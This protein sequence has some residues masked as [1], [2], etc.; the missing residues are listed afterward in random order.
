MEGWILPGSHVPPA[1]TS[2]SLRCWIEPGASGVKEGEEGQ[3]AAVVVV[4]RFPDGG[5]GSAREC[6]KLLA[7]VCAEKRGKTR[8]LEFFGATRRI[9][10]Q[11]RLLCCE[12]LL[13]PFLLFS[14]VFSTFSTPPHPPLRLRL[15][16]N[17]PFYWVNLFTIHFCAE[18]LCPAVYSRHRDRESFFLVSFIS[19]F[20]SLFSFPFFFAP[21]LFP[22]VSPFVEK[23][24]TGFVSG[25]CFAGDHDAVEVRNWEERW[26]DFHAIELLFHWVSIGCRDAWIFL[27]LFSGEMR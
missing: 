2:A 4:T 22:D 8:G 25:L 19:Y 9:D 7:S 11:L 13:F 24:C 1:G 15:Q 20:L 14:P 3:K 23:G 26:L 18:S 5:G 6:W 27:T 16:R 12:L 21:A 10:F 17:N